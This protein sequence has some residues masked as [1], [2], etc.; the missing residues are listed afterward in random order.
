MMEKAND[1]PVFPDEPGRLVMR[2]SSGEPLELS[3][4]AACIAK[5][6]PEIGVTQYTNHLIANRTMAN[7]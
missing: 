4:G 5:Q 2:A 6:L 1:W 7:D 3:F